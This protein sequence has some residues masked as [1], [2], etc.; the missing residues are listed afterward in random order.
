MENTIQRRSTS[1]RRLAA[2]IMSTE[3]AVALHA[4]SYPQKMTSTVFELSG[5]HEWAETGLATEGV[6]CSLRRGPGPQSSEYAIHE[7]GAGH[8]ECRPVTNWFKR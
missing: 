3:A 2:V 5:V 8:A 7:A 1:A 4:F 6:Q